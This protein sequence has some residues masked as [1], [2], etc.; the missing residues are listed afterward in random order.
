LIADDRETMRTALRV[1]I[2][3]HPH[4][5]VC[6]EAEDGR[7]AELKAAELQPDLIVLDFAMPVKDGLSAGRDIA[8]TLPA[9]PIVMYTIFDTPELKLEAKKMGLRQVIGK[10][11]GVRRLFSAM[12][13]ELSSSAQPA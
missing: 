10:A 5:Q 11:D 1:L 6:G 9:V 3:A 4:W 8:R 2:E 12:E 7:Q 13:S